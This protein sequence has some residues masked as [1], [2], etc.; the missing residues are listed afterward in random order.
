MRARKAASTLASTEHIGVDGAKCGLSRAL[1]TVD[2]LLVEKLRADTSSRAVVC[3]A[4]K[5]S[6]MHGCSSVLA[7][8]FL[9][10]PDRG[11]TL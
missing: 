3:H 5:K 1:N 8:Q 4:S 11:Q 7:R 10:K 2:E 9:T 6:C